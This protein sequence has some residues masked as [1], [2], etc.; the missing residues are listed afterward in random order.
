MDNRRH[1]LRSLLAAPVI[2]AGC[3]HSA[4]QSQ[5]TPAATSGALVPA[6]VPP[7]GSPRRVI[8][9]VADG[10]SSGTLACADHYSQIHRGRRLTWFELLRRDD[11]QV[12]VMDVRSQ[13]SLVTDSSA[14]SSAW[15]SGVRIPNGKV[16]QASNGRPLVTLFEL[17][18]EAGWKRGLVTTTEITHATPAGF[19]ASVK[20]RSDAE[21]IAAQYLERR[22]DLALGGGRK[23]FLADQRKD[24]RDLRAAYREAGYAVLE[25]PQDLRQAPRDQRWIGIFASSHL[26]FLVDQR[27]GLTKVDPTPSLA[28][29]TTAALKQFADSERF[30]LQVEGGR[31]DHGAHNNDAAASILELIA[32]DEALDVCLEFQKEHPDTL[33]VMTTDH[34]TGN[35]GLNGMGDNYAKSSELFRNV[36]KMKQSLPEIITRINLAETPKDKLAVLKQSAGYSPS[37]RRLDLLQPFLQKKGY[38]LF[39]GLNSDLGALGQVLGNHFGISFTST[40]HTS[41]HVPVL[42]VGPGADQFRGFVENTQI[43][44]HYLAFAGIRFHNPQERL[45]AAVDAW[46]GTVDGHHV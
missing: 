20:S 9:L 5:K 30:V 34:G 46:A 44:D 35:P 13:N 38:S 1:F 16:N 24:K 17:L 11:V 21:D 31:V 12:A 2:G 42:A 6:Y 4:S 15:G 27:G 10:M 7:A 29:M 36:S 25:T 43:F 14:S 8:H 32:F 18:G 37:T 39:D 22:V 40:A 45:V 23:Y 41:D 26:P 19:A 3:A 33:L 28:E